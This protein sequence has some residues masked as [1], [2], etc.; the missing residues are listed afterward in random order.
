MGKDDLNFYKHRDWKPGS[1]AA[2]Q[3]VPVKVMDTPE[4]VK[5]D[6]SG[7]SPW[8]KAGTWE[9]KGQK[10]WAIEHLES[11]LVGLK[12]EKEG[13]GAVEVKELTCT[14]D[15]SITFTRGKKKWPYDFKLEVCP[16]GLPT[17]F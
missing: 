12:H 14:G 16:L 1:D 5:A 13:Y 11:L 15:A 2:P 3:A 9:E 10:G 4:E 8:N 7:S 6:P 17:F